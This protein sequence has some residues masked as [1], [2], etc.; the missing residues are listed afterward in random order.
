MAASG[1]VSEPKLAREQCK[2]QAKMFR[3]RHRAIGGLAPM[4][5][6]RS[7]GTLRV[8][9]LTKSILLPPKSQRLWP[10]WVVSAAPT[11]GPND[12]DRTRRAPTSAIRDQVGQSQKGRDALQL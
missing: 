3:L 9:G 4:A 10:R 12:R 8:F 1:F 2:T 11:V 6:S 7:G 5:D